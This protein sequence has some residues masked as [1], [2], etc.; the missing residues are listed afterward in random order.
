MDFQEFYRKHRTAIIICVIA[1]LAVGLLFQIF[2]QWHSVFSLSFWGNVIFWLPLL[3]IYKFLTILLLLVLVI[4]G[5]YLASRL[6]PR[7]RQFLVHCIQFVR[8]F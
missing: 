5:L 3:V 1:Y 4:G 6:S 7:F 8:S 2:A